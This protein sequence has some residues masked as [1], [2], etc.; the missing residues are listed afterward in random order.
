MVD[1]DGLN[2]GKDVSLASH[3]NWRGAGKVGDIP[4]SSRSQRQDVNPQLLILPIFVLQRQAEPS[5]CF[6]SC[7]FAQIKTGA[8]GLGIRLVFMQVQFIRS[9]RVTTRLDVAS[10]QTPSVFASPFQPASQNNK[11]GVAS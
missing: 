1:E 11:S 4:Q 3:V 9:S 2:I 8:P 5:A 7:R 6:V 10:F